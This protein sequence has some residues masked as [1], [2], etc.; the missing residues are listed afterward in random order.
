VVCL[1]AELR[2][3]RSVFV[4]VIAKTELYFSL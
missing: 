2:V 3:S 1:A 4:M